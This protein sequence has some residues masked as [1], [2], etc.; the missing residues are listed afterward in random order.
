MLRTARAQA[1]GD[2]QVVLTELLPGPDQAWLPGP[3]GQ[4]YFSELR[5]HMRDPMPAGTIERGEDR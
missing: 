1:G 3:G 5:I 2:T 4:R